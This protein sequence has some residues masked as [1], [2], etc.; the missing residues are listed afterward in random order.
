MVKS[1]SVPASMKLRLCQPKTK[2][3]EFSQRLEARGASWLT[4]HA[5]TASAR[6]RRQGAADLHEVKR[7]KDGLSIPVIS[8]GNVRNHTDLWDNLALTGADGLMI[9]ET[10][11]GNPW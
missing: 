1:F 5:R 10:L 2:T 8:N 6:R 7:L 3:L 9:G 4:L 11:L